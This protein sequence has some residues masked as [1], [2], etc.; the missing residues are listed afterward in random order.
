MKKSPLY[1]F[2]FGILFYEII[3]PIL[4]NV[5]EIINGFCQLAVGKQAVQMTKYNE[6]IAKYKESLNNESEQ[7]SVIGFSIPSYSDDEEEEDDE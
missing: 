1:F 3:L 2:L 6:A 4:S 7:T 5:M